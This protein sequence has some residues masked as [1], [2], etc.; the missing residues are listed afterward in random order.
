[1]AID[2][3]PSPEADFDD[4]DFQFLTTEEAKKRSN[5][6]PLADIVKLNP[7]TKSKFVEERATYLTEKIADSN[8]RLRFK[9]DKK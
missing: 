1:M 9:E 5:M 8:E 6:V 7:S 2:H 4:Y 3:L